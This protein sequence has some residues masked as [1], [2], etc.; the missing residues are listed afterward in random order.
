MQLS[1]SPGW[2]L[3]RLLDSQR[4][5]LD[6]FA[7]SDA[8]NFVDQS[9][10]TNTSSPSAMYIAAITY[11]RRNEKDKAAEVLEAIRSHV[12]PTS[13]PAD[14]ASFLEGKTTGRRWS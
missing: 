9:G 8:T 3:T 4:L 11:L 6:G 1:P 2:Y 7:I 13:W 10:W 12:A 14:I 5:G